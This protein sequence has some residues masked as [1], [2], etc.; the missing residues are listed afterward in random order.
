MLYIWVVVN[1]KV[2]CWVLLILRHLLFKVP[3]RDLN[4]DNYPYGMEPQSPET[5]LVVGLG[6][7][8]N[9]SGPCIH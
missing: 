6:F 7:R 1:I 2:P 9:C 4:F 5:V 3:K 8:L